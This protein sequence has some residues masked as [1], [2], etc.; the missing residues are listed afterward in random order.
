MAQPGVVGTEAAE[1]TRTAKEGRDPRV[2]ERTVLVLRDPKPFDSLTWLLNATPGQLSYRAYRV[3]EDATANCE[4][5]A[6]LLPAWAFS[7]EAVLEQQDLVCTLAVRAFEHGLP[8]DV[9]PEEREALLAL[10]AL[11]REHYW[12]IPDGDGWRTRHNAHLLTV[13]SVLGAARDLWAILGGEA[14]LRRC[15]APARGHSDHNLTCGR[16]F[17]SGGK[18]GRPKRFC[19]DACAKRDSRARKLV[20]E[21]D[22]QE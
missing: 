19:S 2:S 15:E 4:H 8:V 1:A 17:V 21:R 5:Y 3:E 12:W 16:Y 20:A 7:K 11:P 22:R 13:T 14:E 10:A 6:H 9:S 18:I